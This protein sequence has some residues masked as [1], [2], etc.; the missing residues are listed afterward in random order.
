MRITVSQRKQ[1]PA[2]KYRWKTFLKKREQQTQKNALVTPPPLPTLTSSWTVLTKKGKEERHYLHR[3]Y[4][5]IDWAFKSNGFNCHL[6]F[7]NEQIRLWKGCF[8]FLC[9][10]NCV[11]YLFESPVSKF[12]NGVRKKDLYSCPRYGKSTCQRHK[13]AFLT[14]PLH[15]G[16]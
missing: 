5:V 11:V 15:G 16:R 7:F 8:Q 9:N 14:L 13:Y 2:I 1:R 3:R 6:R 4:C 10:V 12:D